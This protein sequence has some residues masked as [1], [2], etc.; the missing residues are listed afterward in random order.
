MKTSR[1]DFIR[2]GVLA[3]AGLA[4]VPYCICCPERERE[5]NCWIAVVFYTEGNVG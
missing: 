1:R 4:L 2:T 5:R 3:T